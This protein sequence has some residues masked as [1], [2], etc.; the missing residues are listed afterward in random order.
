MTRLFHV[1]EDGPFEVMRPRRS[2]AGTQYEG[3]DFVWAIDEPHLVNYLL[4][5]ECSRVCWKA[6]ALARRGLLSSPADRVI[7]VE[8]GW[9]SS[10][11]HARLVVHDLE[12]GGF[13]MLDAV[14]GY[15]VSKHRV[16]VR[17]VEEI[18][19]CSGA[20]AERAAELRLTASLWP[21]VDAVVAAGAEFS[22][23]RM[24]NAQPREER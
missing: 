6:T 4:P 1:S 2:P 14:A 23:I 12:P 3:Q 13:S 11:R 16:R 7:A 21:Y 22:A 9:M 10:L 19:D 24:R 17:A 20:I 8:Q 5:R 15:W 18:E